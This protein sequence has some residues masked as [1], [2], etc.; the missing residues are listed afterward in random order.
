M[1]CATHYLKYRDRQLITSD[2]LAAAT[3]RRVI[4]HDALRKAHG[5]EPTFSEIETVIDNAL[6]WQVSTNF[7]A[8][9]YL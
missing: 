6:S 2:Q 3:I 5:Q 1:A 9:I 4:F 7:C 8:G